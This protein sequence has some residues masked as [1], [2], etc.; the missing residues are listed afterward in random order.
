MNKIWV[1]A[2]REYLATVRTKMFV[3]SLVLMPVMMGGGAIAS[4]LAKKL[5]DRGEKVFAV[6]D[7]TP[8]KKLLPIL[9]A[10][11]ERRN[12]EETTNKQTGERKAV[13]FRLE[14]VEPSADQPEAIREQ[15]LELSDRVQKG[16]LAGFLDIGADAMKQ[17]SVVSALL[18][19]ISKVAA[20]KAEPKDASSTTDVK[21]TKKKA[22][23]REIT[24]FQSR[25]T[26]TGAME[27][28]RWA[29][30]EITLA[31]RLGLGTAQLS[32]QQMQEAMARPP[33]V[34]QGLSTRNK[35]TGAIEDDEVGV[36]SMFSFFLAAAL[37]V[38]M[39]MVVMVAASPLLQS[40][41]EEKMQRISEVLLGSVSPFEL[42]AGKLL[43]SV[44]VS[45][46]LSAIY[47]GGA[48]WLA[49][50]YNVTE[51]IPTPLLGWFLFYQALALFMYG[52]MFIAVGA[53]CE[54]MKDAQSLM[55]PAMLPM[56][57][58]MFFIGPVLLEPEGIVSRVLSYVPTATPMI[59][60]SRQTMNA[61]IAWW[62]PI[63]GSAVVFLTTAVCVWAA[64]RIFRVGI[65][66]QGKSAKLGQ[67]LSWIWS[68]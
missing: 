51:Q 21:A 3:V 7:R 31:T 39:L 32:S 29:Q 52:S 47:L 36:K 38:L 4:I 11:V 19:G 24:R 13:A 27:F 65:L 58:P 33:I 35:Q 50:F 6:V 56:M 5:E 23:D 53:A 59:M 66:M 9:Q 30:L 57:I 60:L 49:H 44:G 43:G 63:V 2:K 48:Y 26:I 54:E 37:I 25:P 18:Q 1:I 64:G 14:P 20:P 62:E 22:D 45:L 8:G 67:M 17:G 61:G 41:L 34:F 16:K 10:G 46:T 12:A 42:M 40:V 68:G 15:R 55:M 28:F